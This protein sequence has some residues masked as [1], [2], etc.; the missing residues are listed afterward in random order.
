MVGKHAFTFGASFRN[1]NLKIHFNLAG[2]DN[3]GW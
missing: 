1:I 3:L 2:Y